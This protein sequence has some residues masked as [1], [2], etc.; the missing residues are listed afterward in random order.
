M[1]QSKATSESKKV[2]VNDLSIG[3]VL[4]LEG[5]AVADPASNNILLAEQFQIVDRIQQEKD[6]CICV[7]FDDFV[8]AF[9]SGYEVTAK[10]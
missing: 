2:K 10:R 8:C 6:N 1:V 4:D 9:P 7:Y 5:D 3:M